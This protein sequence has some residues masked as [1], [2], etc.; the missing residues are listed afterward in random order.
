MLTMS[1][2]APPSVAGTTGPADGIDG[3]QVQALRRYQRRLLF[4]GGGALTLLLV[5]SAVGLLAMLLLRFDAEQRQVFQEGRQA[6]VRVMVQR[7]RAYA[8]SVNS[9][10]NLWLTQ[11]AQ[12]IERG[13]PLAQRF[14]AQRGQLV[15]LAPGPQSIPWLVLGHSQRPIPEPRLA[16]YLG[17]LLDYSAY[18]SATVAGIESPTPQFTYAFATQDNLLAVA[19]VTDAAPLLQALGVTNTDEAV[20]RLTAS[21]GAA[22][23]LAGPAVSAPGVTARTLRQSRLQTYTGRNPFTG[24]PALVSDVVLTAR[25]QPYFHRVVFES[26]DNLR[27]VLGEAAPGRF[28]VIAANGARV[29]DSG[30]PRVPASLLARVHVGADVNAGPTA[31]WAGGAMV[32]AAPV[33]GVDWTLVRVYGWPEVWADQGLGWLVILGTT[34]MIVCLLW[35][36]LLRLD[37]RVFAPALVDA[38]RVYESEALSRTLLDTSP[39]GLCLLARTDGR[40]IVRNPAFAALEQTLRPALPD[41]LARQLPAEPVQGS[42]Q[43]QL[44]LDGCDGSPRQLQVVWVSAQFQRQ[45]VW[46]CTVRDTTTQA[47]L[48]A[49]LRSARSDAEAASRAKTAFV[50]TMSHEIRTPLNGVI[51][52]LELLGRLPL[53]DEQR[54]RVQRV[55]VSANA[56][57]GIVSDVLD[58]SRIE[59]GLMD[60]DPQPFALRPLLEQAALLFAP[61]ALAK[62]VAVYLYVHPR[63]ADHYVADAHR[64]AQII[65]NLASNAV[66]FTHAGQVVLAM[67][68]AGTPLRPALRLE[69][70]DT[71]IG[72]TP[73]QLARLFQPFTQA[74]AGTAH[75]YGG[76]GLGLALCR[77]LAQLLGGTLGVRSQAGQ[78]AVF[79]LDVPVQ[80]GPADGRERPLAGRRVRLGPGPAPWRADTR[81][82]LHRW[83]AGVERDAPGRPSGLSTAVEAVQVCFAAAGEAVDG[84]GCPSQGDTV[85]QILM[86]PDGPLLPVRAGNGAV[87]SC[88]ASQALLAAL[89][90]ESAGAPAAAQAAPSRLQGTVLLVDDNAVNRELIEHQ[91][92]LLG[93]QVTVASNGEQAIGQW[94]TGRFAAVLADLNMPGMDGYE[95]VRH[96]RAQDAQ[97]P[98]LAVTAS[99]LAGDKQR[100][101][102]VGVNAVLLKPLT[103]E[104]LQAALQPWLGGTATATPAVLPFVHGAQVQKRMQQA[105]LRTGSADLMQLRAAL[106]PYDRCV[107]AQVLHAFAGALGMLGEQALAERCLQAE[108]PLKEGGPPPAVAQL[109]ALADDLQNLLTRYAHEV[110]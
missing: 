26:F 42:L 57:L 110:A 99:A 107:L 10:D 50:A 73:E 6:L 33:R 44:G 40:M 16:A 90:P 29:L 92:G 28:A 3:D 84:E 25:G 100:C 17:M 75:R 70:S 108:Q 8:A 52:H 93:L 43:Q 96:L 65:N 2:Y 106:A 9:N 97:V 45:P 89:L 79:T 23:A 67:T 39:V 49:H 4:W 55:Q 19:G 81:G 94:Q 80:P 22:I 102:E 76:S 77:Q 72:M 104:R 101:R 47:E 11:Q 20:E 86:R 32:L 95:L 74:E 12:L 37:R 46:V 62:G 103:L 63:L 38:A 15:V 14:G 1:G 109:L 58:F 31:A 41:T 71:G 60:L 27:R 66:K 56:L 85:L 105:L 64:L 88:Y 34:T 59:A 5:A 53:G 78:G 69:V 68:P 51:G 30:Q 24:Q 82:L 13:T 48:E 7:D 54:E 36:L 87:I 91:L 83:G 98:I 61:Q 18:A 21:R 35:F